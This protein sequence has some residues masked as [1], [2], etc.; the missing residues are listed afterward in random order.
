MLLELLWGFFGIRTIQKLGAR[1]LQ[2]VQDG[3]KQEKD[4]LFF[5]KRKK[6]WSMSQIPARIELTFDKKLIHNY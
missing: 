2:F 1:I 5:L 6:P 4:F 3:E